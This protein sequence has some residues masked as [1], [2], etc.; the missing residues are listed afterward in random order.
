MPHLT[1]APFMT[2]APFIE[3]RL[4]V[5]IGVS[6]CGKTTLGSSLSAAITALFMDAD[7]FHPAQNVEKMR[8]GIAL[9]DA[10]R[11]PW[12]ATLNSEIKARL[13]TGRSVVVA[14]SALKQSYRAA[15]AA[16]ISNVDWIFLD[17]DFDAVAARLRG[18]ENHY[19]P[20]SLL[21]SQFDALERPADAICVPIELDPAAQVTAVLAALSR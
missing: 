16:E 6:G 19:M 15:I 13:A 18:R 20:E 12:L 2:F 21:R 11:A 17:G 8:T 1:L 5:V 4:I 10:D 7:D 14:C 3:P 9:T